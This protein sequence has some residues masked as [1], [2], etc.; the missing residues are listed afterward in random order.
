MFKRLKEKWKVSW[1]QFLLIFTT[2]ALGGSLCARLGSQILH[3][4]LD[5]ESVWY[6]ILYVPLVTIL[7]PMCVILISI[8]FG[9][10]RFFTN[11]LRNMANKMGLR[12]K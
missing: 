10:F 12:R 8:P 3:Y 11:Y 4:A 5:E 6:W 7:W 2:F 1:W 9:Q